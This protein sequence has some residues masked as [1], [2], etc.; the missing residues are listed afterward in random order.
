MFYHHF[1][2][3]GIQKTGF[4]HTKQKENLEKLRKSP[5]LDLQKIYALGIKVYFIVYNIGYLC[6]IFF[7]LVSHNQAFIITHTEKLNIS[8]KRF[9]WLL[10]FPAITN[11]IFFL[12]TFSGCFVIWF[13]NQ[14]MFW[15]LILQIFFCFSIRNYLIFHSYFTRLASN[16]GKCLL[17]YPG[18]FWILFCFRF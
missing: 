3:S 11:C 1:I 5:V 10:A 2:I 4:I 6:L 9:I 15:W 18:L 13:I 14:L 12:I 17:Q 16:S 7:P 8:Y